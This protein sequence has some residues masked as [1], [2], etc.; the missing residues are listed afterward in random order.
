[1]TVPSGRNSKPR[2]APIPSRCTLT[3]MKSSILILAILLLSLTLYS[4]GCLSKDNVLLEKE[5]NSIVKR[6]NDLSL[7]SLKIQTKNKKSQFT[8][9]KYINRLKILNHNYSDN[10]FK[11]IFYRYEFLKTFPDAFQCKNTICIESTFSGEK[12]TIEKTVISFYNMDS[13]IIDHY[14]LVLGNWE[15]ITTTKGKYLIINRNFESYRSKDGDN[16][17]DEVILSDFNC[18]SV[19]KSSYFC[20]YNLLTKDFKKLIK[21]L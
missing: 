14:E 17:A 4:Q 20:Q 21:Y 2:T 18:C 7:K 19:L 9:S 8:R 15:R 16:L 5:I 3:L 13:I 1:L 11:D 10:V 6:W 12:I